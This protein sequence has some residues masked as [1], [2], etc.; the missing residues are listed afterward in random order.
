MLVDWSCR[1]SGSSC[2][3]SQRYLRNTSSNN[4][5]CQLF[6]ICYLSWVRQTQSSTTCRQN[7]PSI[8]IVVIPKEGLGAGSHQSFFWYDLC[9]LQVTNLY[10]RLADLKKEAFKGH[11]HLR[12]MILLCI[13]N[14]CNGS[15]TV[16]NC[17]FYDHP[18]HLLPLS[19]I[20]RPRCRWP[21]I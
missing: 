16:R 14:W 4:Y 5:N 13:I 1:K 11:L 3:K 6:T 12:W 18:F 20:L 17:P 9:K 8:F 10:N 21:L 15:I 2:I 19:K 7:V